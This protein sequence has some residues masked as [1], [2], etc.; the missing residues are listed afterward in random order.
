MKVKVEWGVWDYEIQAF[1]VSD[2]IRPSA[3]A[4]NELAYRIAISL[5]K[6]STRCMR[7][8]FLRVTRDAPAKTW[9]NGNFTSWVSAEIVDPA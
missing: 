2:S 3:K 4:A 8:D 1:R 7:G 5:G 9:R 6:A